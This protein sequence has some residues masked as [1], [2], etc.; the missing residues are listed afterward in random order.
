MLNEHYDIQKTLCV[1]PYINLELPV[2]PYKKY[3]IH[4]HSASDLLTDVLYHFLITINQISSHSYKNEKTTQHG[5]QTIFDKNLL[6]DF[7]D[8]LVSVLHEMNT[9]TMCTQNSVLLKN[10]MK[11]KF[12]PDRVRSQTAVNITSDLL[13]LYCVFFPYGAATQRG[14][15]PPHS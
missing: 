15:W 7:V 12:P 13:S 8:V 1:F 10:D 5:I 9:F 4:S 2:H 6:S 14:S 11:C 3:K